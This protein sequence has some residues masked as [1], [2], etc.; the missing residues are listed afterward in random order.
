MY[1]A[2]HLLQSCRQTPGIRRTYRQMEARKLN[3]SFFCQHLENYAHLTHKCHSLLFSQVNLIRGV[4]VMFLC[5][6]NTFATRFHRHVWVHQ[7]ENIFPGR[8]HLCHGT[9]KRRLFIYCPLW[10]SVRYKASIGLSLRHL[11]PQSLWSTKLQNRAALLSRLW[12][13]HV[14]KTLMTLTV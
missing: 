1:T 12:I 14:Q 5:K 9:R 3:A 4:N 2:S 6:L 8:Q 13:W 11:L 10:A 7:G